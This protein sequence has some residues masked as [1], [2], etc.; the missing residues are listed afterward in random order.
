MK[1]RSIPES[2]YL[3]FSKFLWYSAVADSCPPRVQDQEDANRNLASM[4]HHWEE[5]V[6]MADHTRNEMQEKLDN[7]MRSEPLAS[8]F[9]MGRE[10]KA[11]KTQVCACVFV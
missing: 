10:L 8:M 9:A 11:S 2:G 6:R 5:A 7:L 1:T 3:F 4:R